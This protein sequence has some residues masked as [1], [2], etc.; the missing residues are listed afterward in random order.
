MCARRTIRVETT[1]Y[2]PRVDRVAGKEARVIFYM[3]RRDGKG[4]GESLL[5][6]RGVATTALIML[7]T[8]SRGFIFS[9]HAEIGVSRREP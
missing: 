1:A 6:N 8:R 3:R 7:N 9:Q 2:R 5:M 4:R